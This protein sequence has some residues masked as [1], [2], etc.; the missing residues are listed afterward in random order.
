MA[1]AE[2]ENVRPERDNT[3]VM[4]PPALQA[5]RGVAVLARMYLIGPFALTGADGQHLT[6]RAQ[7][8]RAI[9]AMLALAPRGSR[10]RVW[11]RDKLWSDRAEDQASASL[12]QALL[13]IRRS[14]GPLA[15]LVLVADNHT[16][17]LNLARVSVDALEVLADRIPL[18]L[19]RETD[20]EAA[21]EHFLEGLDVRD[22]E[23]EDW[24]LMERQVWQQ[25][26]ETQLARGLDPKHELTAQARHRNLSVPRT[27]HGVPAQVTQITPAPRLARA[28]IALLPC[29]HQ[30]DDPAAPEALRQLP[31][32]AQ[33]ICAMLATA[34]RESGDLHL[35]NF[36]IG[37]FT[38]V[39]TT[40]RFPEA[41]VLHLVLRPKIALSGDAAE[42][43]LH[44]MRAG[45]HG[46]VWSRTARCN[47][48][49]LAAGDMSPL[50]HLVSA[51]VEAALDWAARA[52]QDERQMRAAR[53]Y[54][55]ASRMFGLA[56]DDLAASEA[57][58]QDELATRP[59]AQAYGW[60]AFLRTFQ[61]GQRH[62]ADDAPVI[63]EAQFYARR[64]LE[65][66]REN[67]LTSALV[68]HIHSY[69]FG[70]YDFAAGL[71]EHAL[72]LNPGQT[73]GWDLYAMLHA[74]AGQPKRGLAMSRWAVHLAE[75]SP[76]RFYFETTRC[77][78]AAL[79]GDPETAIAA[80]ES[81]L[82]DRPEFN[83]ILR[84]LVS[85]YAH[86]GRMDEAHDR[87]RK[88]YAIEPAFT[89]QSLTASGYPGLD[90]SGG[91]LFTEGLLK[92][93]VRM[94]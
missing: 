87:L 93:G 3:L 13:D 88:L 16:V 12:R 22:P 90:T 65:L 91:R 10:S 47:L 55:A 28:G 32:A 69:L 23:F 60:L 11:L 86:A 6:P 64:S 89:I 19:G 44:L 17:S 56:R 9:L 62:S 51:L 37:T 66:D 82:L 15:D 61:V 45:D 21:T 92:A 39:D 8:S 53:L 31:G 43:T 71:F 7:K 2:I 46:T 74:Y 85:A 42:V 59:S 75:G 83:S 78:A 52:P 63:E 76:N 68:G 40:P 26:L 54:T 38:P 24:L 41:A 50:Y 73:L 30:A 57:L 27:E 79:S 5:L 18:P 81:A 20:E 72:R 14:L 4:P 67:A 58:L 77:I 33:R 94:R 48:S 70:E 49:A 25:K 34:L 1:G 80:G 84:Y 35:T 36:T 29:H